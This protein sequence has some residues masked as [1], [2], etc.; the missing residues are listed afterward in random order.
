[1]RTTDDRYRGE[2][3]R[4]ELA[5]RMIRHEARTG[6]IRYV[7]SL[8]DD[9]I[10]KLYTSY[11]KYDANKNVKRRRGKTPTQITPLIRTPARTLESG[12]FVRL[13]LVS[14]LVDVAAPPGPA[15]HGNI[16]LG[17]RFCRCFEVYRTV[18][19]SPTLT[20][21]WAWNLLMT[22]RRGDE[23]GIDRCACC[24]T[25]YLRDLL[26][27]PKAACPACPT[28]CPAAAST[29]ARSGPLPA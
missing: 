7:T 15:L 25:V 5:L 24:G 14:G 27:L 16:E 20:F 10:R 13:L 1:M 9:R 3:S 18:V 22:V 8:S 17:N 21:E 23:I 26:T 11:F 2:K 28:L 4:F 29:M 19:P 6:T 12:V